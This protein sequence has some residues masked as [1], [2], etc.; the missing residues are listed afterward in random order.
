MPDFV[1][2]VAFHEPRGK[3]SAKATAVSRSVGLPRLL[4]ARRFGA[5]GG[6]Q[7]VQ[8]FKARNF[9]SEN[10]FPRFTAELEKNGGSAT[11]CPVTNG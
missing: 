4:V 7:P 3:S 1:I 8:G 5:A 2:V 6:E 9:V 10:S 11:W